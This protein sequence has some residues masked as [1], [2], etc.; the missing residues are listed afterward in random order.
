MNSIA[1][2]QSQ[3]DPAGF[4]FSKEDFNTL[5]AFALRHFGLSLPE[6]KM[7]MVYTRLW[8]RL[9]ACGLKDFGDYCRLIED[10]SGI[11]EREALLSALTT[12]VT[13]FFRE[14]HHFDTLQK[15]ILPPLIKA[16]KK[17]QRIRLW[18]AGCS[19]GQEPY[20]IAMCILNLC[21]EAPEFDIKIL[22]TDIDPSVIGQAKVGCYDREDLDQIPEKM[23]TEHVIFSDED[24]VTGEVGP[25]AKSLVSFGVLNLIE[26]L[27][28][29]GPFDVIFCRNVTIYFDQPTQANVWSTFNEVLTKGGYLFAGHSERLSGPACS[30]LRSAG[31]TTYTKA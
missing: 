16:A 24:A 17:G 23:R 8:R 30:S 1:R 3:Y 19:T 28:F 7:P 25:A 10:P 14:P 26:P 29:S 12:N 27:P 2:T 31:I 13:R 5:A 18:S 22:G 11:Q 21:P 4:N 20:S 15:L 6:S 9:Q